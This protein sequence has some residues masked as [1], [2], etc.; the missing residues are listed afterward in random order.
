M[1]SFEKIQKQYTPLIHK[2]MNT[3]HIYKNKDEFYQTGLISLWK[4]W[5]DFD[6]TKGSFTGYAYSSIKGTMMKE[7]TAATKRTDTLVYPEEEYWNSI[8]NEHHTLN[9]NLNDK[10]TLL[11]YC[12]ELTPNQTKWVIET[13]LEGRAIKEIAAKEGVSISTVKK[14]RAGAKEK[15]RS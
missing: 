4:A 15:I 2:I 5:M 1:D 13:F 7:L 9:V 14:W 6:H 12:T 8:E 11:T 10:E 3:L